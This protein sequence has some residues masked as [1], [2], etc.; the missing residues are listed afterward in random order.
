MITLNKVIKLLNN[1]ATDH[2]QINSWGFGD[3]WEAGVTTKLSFP[4]MWASLN[5]AQINGNEVNLNFTIYLMDKVRRSEANEN[6]VLSDTLQIGLDVI[7]KLRELEN[8]NDFYLVRSNA[9]EYFTE[10]LD[11]EVSGITLAVTIKIPNLY[12]NC[13]I[14]D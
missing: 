13:S 10:S 1:I 7:A 8:T 3:L 12:D 5:P 14:P 11:D 9:I 6:D 2:K 4:A